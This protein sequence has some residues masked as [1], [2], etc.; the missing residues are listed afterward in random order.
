M[1]LLTSSVHPDGP[2]VPFAVQYLSDRLGKCRP[3]IHAS[4]N[5]RYVNLPENGS[6]GLS[7]N[8]MPPH[9]LTFDS[10]VLTL[11]APPGPWP[12]ML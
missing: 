4:G 3:S 1:L 8:F 9:F 11:N 5:G 12:D 2:L 10:S 6:A 7:D